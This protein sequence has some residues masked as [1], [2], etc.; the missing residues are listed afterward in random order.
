[1]LKNNLIESLEKLFALG[2]NHDTTRLLEI[3]REFINFLKEDDQL[4]IPHADENIVLAKDAVAFIDAQILDATTSNKTEAGNHLKPFFERLMNSEEWSYYELRTL[5]GSLS[6][7]SNVEQSISLANKAVM[8]LMNFNTPH[9]GIWSGVI[10]FHVLSRIL[11]AKFFEDDI[12]I[13][14]DEAFG[15]WFVKLKHQVPDNP[16]LQMYLEIAEVKQAIFKKDN[17]AIMLLMRE[18]EEKYDKEVVRVVTSEVDYYVASK[19]YNP[20]FHE[21]LKNN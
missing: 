4:L 7:T 21:I 16:E 20:K 8:V 6:L 18:F 11:Y 5:G 3:R 1:M 10:A 13:D 12:T 19:K 9:S 15:Q 14:L 17:Q 2:N